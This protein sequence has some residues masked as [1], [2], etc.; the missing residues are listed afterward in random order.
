MSILEIAG[1]ITGIAAALVVIWQVLRWGYAL[2]E[3]QRC[4]LRSEMTRLYYRN[5]D[6][7]KMRQYEYENF[8]DCY[9][10]YRALNGNSFIV[11]IHG[12]VE[13]WEVTS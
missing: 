7:G 11:K 9:K 5:K 3:G 6:D 2:V 13:K 8:N 12:E 1:W 4:I 10:A